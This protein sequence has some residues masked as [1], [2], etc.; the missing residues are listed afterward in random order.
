LVSG[1]NY[2]YEYVKVENYIKKKQK[3]YIKRAQMYYS[4]DIREKGNKGQHREEKRE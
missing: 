1:K 2:K 3:L 4:R